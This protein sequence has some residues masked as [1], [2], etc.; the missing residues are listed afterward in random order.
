MG[1]LHPC[2]ALA[3]TGLL[4][5][6]RTGA[7]SGSPHLI[8]ESP[9]LQGQLARLLRLSGWGGHCGSS[10]AGGSGFP[11]FLGFTLLV[12]QNC[13]SPG[14]IP[15]PLIPSLIG[16]TVAWLGLYCPPFRNSQC[17]WRDEDYL[18]SSVSPQDARGFNF[19]H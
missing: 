13:S 1:A 5:F 10:S 2:A 18:L 12:T 17:H 8:E 14:H 7:D 3:G 16:G 6:L 4:W 11:H 9:H 15:S 19:L